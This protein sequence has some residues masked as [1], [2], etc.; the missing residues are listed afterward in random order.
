[1][2]PSECDSADYILAQ[3]AVNYARARG[4]TII[5][6]L[7][8]EN[9]DVSDRSGAVNAYFQALYGED[10]G[11]IA[12][13]LGT[14]DGVIGVSSTGYFNE[15]AFYSNYGVG[16]VDIAA[17]GGDPFFQPAPPEYYSEGGLVGAWSST[18]TEIP[19][20]STTDCVGVVCGLYAWQIG[21]SMAAPN[22]AGVAAL[23]VS[24]YGD[25]QNRGGNN[26]DDQ[27]GNNND[28]RSGGNDGR[29][30][31]RPELV[32]RYLL[33]SAVSTPCPS[34]RTVVYGGDYP[35]DQATCQGGAKSNGFYGAGIVN[36]LAALTQR[37][38]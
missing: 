9:L 10:F 34:P 32:E 37:N 21:T 38:N 28:R 26:N 23:I 3:R 29:T 11:P 1:M 19:N 22:V 17:P 4:V 31:L 35:Y 14:L 27:H 33:G 16:S 6:A 5:A 36:A 8:N 13:I 7:G 25:F 24:R 30:H 20:F 2:P 18:A 15:K 12:E